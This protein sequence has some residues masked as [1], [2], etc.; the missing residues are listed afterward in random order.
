LQTVEAEACDVHVFGLRRYFQQ[1]QN[2]HALPDMIGT[3]PAGLAGEVNFLKPLWR[4]PPIM[5][6]V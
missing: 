4:K 2:A 5:L 1:L 6:L 3:D